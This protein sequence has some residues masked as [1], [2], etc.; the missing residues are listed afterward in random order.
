MSETLKP[1]SIGGLTIGFPVVL[2]G[3]AGYTDLP[4]RALCRAGGAEFCTTEMMLD[5]CLLAGVKLR[6]RLAATDSQDHPVAGQLIGNDPV[7][8]AEAAGL[9]CQLGFDVIDLNFACPV[10]KTLRRKRGGH[11]LNEPER[12]VGIVRSVVSACNR[13]VTLKL[14]RKFRQDDSDAAFWSIAEGAF[15]AGAAA[16]TVHSRSVQAKYAGPADWQFLAAVKGRFADRTIVGS[17]DMLTPQAALDALGRTNLDAVAIARGALGNPWFFRQAKDLAEGRQPY[18]P[19]IEDQK[20]VLL[21]HFA[22]ACC[23][24]G[25]D[26]GP[27]IM[28]KFGIKYARLHPAT[29]QVRMAFAGAK[30]PEGWQSVVAEYY[31]AR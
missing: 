2:A 13:P 9:L 29:R 4:Y 31:D 10:N 15:E 24:Y 5:K 16:L 18:A 26:R 28:R 22:D 7:M 14:R 8:M 12:C 27:K 3:M 30:G 25:A 11:L 21:K 23:L 17:G 19:T 20:Q 1:F 6:R